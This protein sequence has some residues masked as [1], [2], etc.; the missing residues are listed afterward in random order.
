MFYFFKDVKS[1]IDE[2]WP[3]NDVTKIGQF[4]QLTGNMHKIF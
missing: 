1:D 4:P 3:V 2:I